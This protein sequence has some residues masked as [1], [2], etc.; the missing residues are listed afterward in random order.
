MARYS[1]HYEN[2]TNLDNI[3]ILTAQAAYVLSKKNGKK[4]SLEQT[5]HRKIPLWI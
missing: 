5:T 1:K 2:I 3:H 4:T